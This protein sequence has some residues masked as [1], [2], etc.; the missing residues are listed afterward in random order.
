MSTSSETIMG[1][2]LEAKAALPQIVKEK[3]DLIMAFGSSMIDAGFSPREFDQQLAQAGINNI[4][5][6]NF[7][8]GGL[9]PFFQDYLSRR[10]K[11]AF[12]ANNR[13]LKLAIIEFNPFQ[14]TITRRNR[15]L[16]LEDSFITLL[17]T[18]KE[19]REILLQD[20]DRGIRLYNI[21]YL[22]GSISAEMI[23][24]YFG[25]MLK[26]QR[27]QTNIQENPELNDK[28]NAI[29]EKL[30][31]KFKQEYPD[32]KNEQWSYT[33]QGGG[34]IPSER[35][36]ETLA[37]FDQY[38]ATQLDPHTLDDNRLSRIYTADILELHFSEELIQAFIR[39]VNQ[40][41]TFSDEVQVVMLPRNTAWINYTPEGKKRLAQ[42]ITT[43]ESAT[44]VTIQNHQ[45]LGVMNPSMFG[46]TTH[47][48]RYHGAHTYTKYLADEYISEKTNNPNSEIE[49]RMSVR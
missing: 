4:K 45:D 10:V 41:K 25:R 35:S 30:N 17:G 43:I 7:G 1:R 42:T 24:N 2:V 5:S 21:K 49:S 29:A 12:D 3:K 27:Q 18:E 28:I 38:Y 31:A 9:N 19:L 26:P 39:I 22:R 23:T 40:F 37:L 20:P 47:L 44:G 48:N 6:F 33:W 36:A 46:D 15:A 32:Y 16:A 34:T 8:F 11:E 13:R 14:S